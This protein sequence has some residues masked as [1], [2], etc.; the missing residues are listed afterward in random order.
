MLGS[1]RLLVLV[2][3][4]SLLINVCYMFEYVYCYMLHVWFKLHLTCINRSIFN[5]ISRYNMLYKWDSEESQ[6]IFF[7]ICIPIL[8]S[9]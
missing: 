8:Q 1:I 6:L 3:F 4:L 9:K 2:V 5:S 7:Q